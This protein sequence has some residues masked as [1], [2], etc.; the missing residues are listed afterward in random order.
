MSAQRS[1]PMPPAGSTTP[2]LDQRCH[3]AS[4]AVPKGDSPVTAFQAMQTPSRWE[5]LGIGIRWSGRAG[6][7]HF[8]AAS[9]RTREGLFTGRKPA[10][11]VSANV[12]RQQDH[13][14]RVPQDHLPMEWTSDS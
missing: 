11:A 6:G 4:T 8:P 13:R 2:A 12:K 1:E 5:D 7:H 14:D 3:T 10:L 9:S